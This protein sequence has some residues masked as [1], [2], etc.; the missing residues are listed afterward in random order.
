MAC[1]LCRKFCRARDENSCYYYHLYDQLEVILPNWKGG[2]EMYLCAQKRTWWA[3]H[4]F[5]I[6]LAALRRNLGV[7]NFSYF[8]ILLLINPLIKLINIFWTYSSL[9]YNNWSLS[10]PWSKPSLFL[11]KH[12]A[13]VQVSLLFDTIEIIPNEKCKEKL[14]H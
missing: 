2:W 12:I 6:F 9:F 11:S 3:E 4:R 13:A 1:G 14:L 10:L 5:T 7:T 8:C